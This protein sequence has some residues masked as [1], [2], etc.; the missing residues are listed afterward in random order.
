MQYILTEE[1]YKTLLDAP[2]K[3]KRE[4]DETIQNLCQIVAD[5]KILTKDDIRWWTENRPWGCIKTVKHEW[6][7]DDCPVKKIC[8]YKSKNFSQ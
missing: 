7:C 4:L 2:N 3:I 5:H 1:E 8:T 6:Y